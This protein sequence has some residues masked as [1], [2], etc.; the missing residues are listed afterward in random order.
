MLIS[1]KLL[2]TVC[3]APWR[4]L[5]LQSS[6]EGCTSK[7]L[8]FINKSSKAR[9]LRPH[10][11]GHRSSVAPENQNKYV[12]IR[13]SPADKVPLEDLFLLQSLNSQ[14]QCLCTLYSG[15]L[16]SSW[17][18]VGLIQITTLLTGQ[19]WGTCSLGHLWIKRQVTLSVWVLLLP[20]SAP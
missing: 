9:L 13:N 11:C 15:S 6:R 7:F 16:F 5:N 2:V 4:T 19:H 17:L 1:L 12:L 20:T 3:G 10:S 14:H 8:P 18:A